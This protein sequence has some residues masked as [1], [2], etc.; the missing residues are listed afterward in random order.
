M[1]FCLITTFFPPYHFGGDGVFVAHLANALARDGHHV[2]VIHDLDSFRLMQ[3]TVQTSG[4]QI[5]PSVQVHTLH[6]GFGPLSP[7]LTYLTGQPWLKQKRI[8]EI[9]DQGFDVIHWHNISLVGGPGAL[10]L[11]CAVKLCTLHEYWMFCPTHILFK[12]NE[13]A[14]TSRSCLRCQIAHHR[15]PQLWRYTSLMERSRREIDRFLAPSRFVQ[16]A[17]RS[18]PEAFETTLLPHFAPPVEHVSQNKKSD[19]SYYLFVGRLEKAKGLQTVLPLFRRTRRKLLIIGAGNYEAELRSQAG[20]DPNVEFLGRVPH[21][22]LPDLYRGARATI[23]P[24]ICYET[25]GLVSIESLRQ[26]TPVISSSFGALPEIIADTGGGVVYKD[27]QALERILDSFD[28]DPESARA[29][30]RQ[31]A[32]KL[33]LYSVERHLESYYRIIEEVRQSKQAVNSL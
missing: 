2:Q 21:A 20:G 10:K 31:G 23:V 27:E 8:D 14:C 33:G 5:E 17:Y 16:N 4:I 3:G 7:L 28:E 11:G 12:N 1:R 19:G 15:P 22:Q 24:S 6:S 13:Q 29:M 32:A 9:L 25:F 26:E 30:G 18:A